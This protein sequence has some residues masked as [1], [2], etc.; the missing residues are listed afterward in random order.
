M[1]SSG[2]AM[3]WPKSYFIENQTA[4]IGV[5]EALGEFPWAKEKI[6]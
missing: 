5:R 4:G 3:E 6:H 2:L 1:I